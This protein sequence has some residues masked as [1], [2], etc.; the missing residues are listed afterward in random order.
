MEVEPRQARC[1]WDQCTPYGVDPLLIHFMLL[2]P[3]LLLCRV[4]VP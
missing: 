3:N 2:Y 1:K 4:I